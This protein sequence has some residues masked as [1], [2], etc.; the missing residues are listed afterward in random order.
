MPVLNEKQ[1]KY[2]FDYYR[3]D[4]PHPKSIVE[5]SEYNGET[6]LAINCTQLG[7]VFTTKY[8]TAKEKKHVLQEL[9]SFLSS[10]TT[11]F[12]ELSFNT[13]FSGKSTL[14]LNLSKVCFLWFYNL[15]RFHFKIS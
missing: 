6:A 5:V 8:K 14:I 4:E 1:I 7:D 10:N 12:T 2:R 9:C 13:Q 3:K 15:C 11:A